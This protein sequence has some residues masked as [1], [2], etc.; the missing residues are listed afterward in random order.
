MVESEDLRALREYKHKYNRVFQNLVKNEIGE[1]SE[2]IKF[3]N[4]NMNQV[5]A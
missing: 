1:I 2:Q 5:M 3:M 4:W